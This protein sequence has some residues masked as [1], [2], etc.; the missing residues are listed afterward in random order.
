[1]KITSN[2]VHQRKHKENQTHPY[3]LHASFLPLIGLPLVVP[4]PEKL[5]RKNGEYKI[6]PNTHISLVIPEDARI[7]LVI[8]KASH[9][10]LVISNDAHIRLMIPKNAHISLVIPNDTHIS[11]VISKDIHISKAHYPIDE[12]NRY[13]TAYT[14][15]STTFTPDNV[16]TDSSV[17]GL[18][19][20]QSNLHFVKLS[21]DTSTQFNSSVSPG[22]CENRR[23]TDVWGMVDG[24]LTIRCDER[25]LGVG[26]HDRTKDAR[27]FWD[28]GDEGGGVDKR[29]TAAEMADS[30]AFVRSCRRR[31]VVACEDDGGGEE[32]LNWM[33]GDGGA[34]GKEG[35]D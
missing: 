35:E 22:A 5:K 29:L 18:A 28:K 9:I 30:L 13:P 11:L 32:T 31:E 6:Y 25:W 19:I 33:G 23:Y 10:S 26:R 24:C 12:A 27:R 2:K 34:V 4:L 21:D 1:M 7:S 14:K 20:N 3:G 17:I 16:Q 15:P 8:P